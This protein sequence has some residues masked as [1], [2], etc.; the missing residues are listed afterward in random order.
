MNPLLN[1]SPQALGEVAIQLIRVAGIM[2]LARHLVPAD[3]GLYRMLLIISSF[4]ILTGEAG[5][6]DALIQRK[7]LSAD[8]EATAWWINS[9]IGI[10]IVGL[11]YYAAPLIAGWPDRQRSPAA[12]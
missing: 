10:L 8:H 7:D 2:Y 1:L 4:A 11:L 6:P 5:L 12:P 9:L 3:F